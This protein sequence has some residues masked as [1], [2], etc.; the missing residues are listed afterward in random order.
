MNVPA[1]ETLYKTAKFEGEYVALEQWF[2]DGDSYMYRIRRINGS[3][4]LVHKSEL[5]NFCL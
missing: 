1:K 5:S 3:K 2:A 4:E